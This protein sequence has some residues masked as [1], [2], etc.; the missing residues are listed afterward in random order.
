MNEE[1]LQENEDQFATN[2]AL[3]PY[4]NTKCFRTSNFTCRAGD[5]VCFQNMTQKV[6]K[7]MDTEK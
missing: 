3:E 5:N 6:D 4:G 1:N 7:I 2:H